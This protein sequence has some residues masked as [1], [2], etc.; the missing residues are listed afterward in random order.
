MKLPPVLVDAPDARGIINGSEYFGVRSVSDRR[1]RDIWNL[2][3]EMTF[4]NAATQNRMFKTW[5]E[6][7][8]A[9]DSNVSLAVA[10]AASGDRSRSG[11][12]A[13]PRT[14]PVRSG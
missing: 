7:A 5:E 4:S 3:P 11:G 13:G 2:T 8:A 12:G 9:D 6:M 14:V 10:A 1:Y